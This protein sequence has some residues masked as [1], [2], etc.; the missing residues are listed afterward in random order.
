MLSVILPAYNEE[1]MIS[2]A[3]E[4]ISNI[5]DSANIDFEI[6]FVDDGSR[7]GT[8]H[9]ICNVIQRINKSERFAAAR[10][11]ILQ[12]IHE[13]E[14]HGRRSRTGTGNIK[15]E[16]KICFRRPLLQILKLHR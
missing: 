13:C 15:N 9:E 5:L 1:Q 4:T 6:V 14:H 3:S 10:K 8:W 7:D 2:K 16:H 11:D 12:I